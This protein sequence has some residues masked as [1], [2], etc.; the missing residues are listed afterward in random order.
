MEF[1]QPRS[2]PEA[3]AV[4]AERPEAVPIAGGTDVMVELNFDRRRPEVVLD[5]TRVPE[6]GSWERSNGGVRVGAGVTYTRMV[7]ELA[8]DL[9]GLAIAA[10]TVGS[11]QI[12]NRGTIG[13]NLGS[14][15]PAGDCH[16][17]LLAVGA[18]VE[19]ASAAGGSRRIPVEAFFTGPKQSALAAGELICAVHVPAATGPQ[20]FAKVGT[21]NAMV[22][23]VCSFALALD[24]TRGRVGTGIGSAGPTPLRAPAAEEFLEGELSSEGLWESR[25][26]LGGAAV[27]RFGELAAAAARPI[28]DVRGTAGYRV[29]AL[30]VMA[31]RTLTWAW[32]QHRTGRS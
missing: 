13:G 23:A 3:L 12:R 9:P 30:G 20:Q 28:D 19:V 16:P 1:L 4:K 25:G 17:P 22:I 18:E 10:R 27:T 11:P 14:A 7:A 24:P 8:D 32:E 2:L 5:L 21:R 15:S 6:L 26:P 31:R 29:H